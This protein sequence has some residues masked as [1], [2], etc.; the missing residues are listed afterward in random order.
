MRIVKVRRV[1]N[2]DGATLPHQ[3][4][5]VGDTPGPSVIFDPAPTGESIPMPENRVRARIRGEIGRRVIAEHREAL[6][7]LAASGHGKAV[8]IDGA[9][10]QLPD[11]SSSPDD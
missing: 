11:C 8:P 1:G 6:E 9:L 2:S 4:E 3:F 5:A 10:G 7:L